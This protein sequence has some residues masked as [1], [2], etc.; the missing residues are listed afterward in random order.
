[1]GSNNYQTCLAV[2][3]Q[4]ENEVEG[5]REREVHERIGGSEQSV[6]PGG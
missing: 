2:G 3:L 4:G 6:C 1:M 5:R